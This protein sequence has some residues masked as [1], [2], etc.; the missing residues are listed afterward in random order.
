MEAKEENTIIDFIPFFEKKSDL[1]P[2]SVMSFEKNVQLWNILLCMFGTYIIHRKGEVVF[3]KQAA[4][5][6]EMR[7]GTHN[8]QNHLQSNFL[9]TVCSDE[10]VRSSLL[11]T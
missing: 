2:K 7:I 8:V 11:S 9:I 5:L 1:K 3:D 6:T 10:K 4:L